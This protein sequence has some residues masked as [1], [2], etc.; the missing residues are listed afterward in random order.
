MTRLLKSILFCLFF[1]LAVPLIAGEPGEVDGRASVIDGDTIEIRGI[2]IRLH[3][4][5]APESGQSCH[6]A[7]DR[8]WRCGQKS[9]LALADQIG[10]SVASCLVSDTDRYGRL[11]ATCAADGRDLNA[12]MVAQGWA[13]AY[14]KYSH[15]YV[16][17]ERAAR[18]AGLGIW[19]GRFTRPDLWRK[20]QR[21]SPA[22]PVR[23]DPAECAIK[24]NIN[25]KGQ[26]IYHLPG[27]E[28][29]DRTRINE[30]KG[31]R[32]FCSEA[33]A[34]KAGWRPAR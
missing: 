11:I 21:T 7:Q 1:P 2:R 33:E 5:D 18:E 28:W 16:A 17:Q 15:D 20:G 19:Q 25:S 31:E 24:G 14:R 4:I 27:T 10:R 8:I 29:Y 30:T 6:D 12:W 13:V 22:A 26:R 34:R 23:S 3:G 32:W 9:A